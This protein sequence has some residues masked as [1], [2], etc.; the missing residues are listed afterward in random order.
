MSNV[1]EVHR[2]EGVTQAPASLGERQRCISP[3]RLEIL[4]ASMTTPGKDS[5]LNLKRHLV[6]NE[7]EIKTPLSRSVK[8]VF[9]RWFRKPIRGE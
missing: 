4:S 1:A 6:R 2:V 7:R 9:R 3:Y 5:A 8:T